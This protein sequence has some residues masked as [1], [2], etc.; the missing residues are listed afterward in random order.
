MGTRNVVLTDY[1]EKIIDQL[2]KS[3]RYQ[4]S[5][6]VIRDALRLIKQRDQEDAA[7]LK[8]LRKAAQ[9]GFDAIEK[10]DYESFA[11]ADEVRSFLRGVAKKARSRSPK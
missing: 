9:Q 8:A 1:H 11:T 3:G 10:G 2:V 5:S 4:N 7:K 6:E